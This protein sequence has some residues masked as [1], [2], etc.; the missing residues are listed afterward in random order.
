MKS[1]WQSHRDQT[2]SVHIPL[3]MWADS[4]TD[5]FPFE[6]TGHNLLTVLARLTD[7][8]KQHLGIL[9]APETLTAPPHA[10]SPKLEPKLLAES[11]PPKCSHQLWSGGQGGADK[12]LKPLGDKCCLIKSVTSTSNFCVCAFNEF[13]TA[14]IC[15]RTHARALNTLIHKTIET[16]EEVMAPGLA[17]WEQTFSQGSGLLLFPTR[18]P[19][20][21]RTRQARRLIP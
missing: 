6:H 4:A 7:I 8:I 14:N 21:P 19:P 9:N 15:A 1:A 13:K 17:I 18:G 12:Q 5:A 3:R 20:Q 11:Y 2:C 10:P 16:I